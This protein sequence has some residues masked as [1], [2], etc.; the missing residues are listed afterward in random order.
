MSTWALAFDVV[1][2]VLLVATISYAAVLNRKLSALRSAKDEL[3]KLLGSFGEATARAD[4]GLEAIRQA[5]A[6]SGQALQSQVE[7]ARSLTAD[8]QFLV[9]RAGLAA[10]KTESAI[11]NDR[12]EAVGK[13]VST[14]ARK[15]AASGALAS[16]AGRET[17]RAAPKPVFKGTAAVRPRPRQA[18]PEPQVSDEQVALIKALDGV[19]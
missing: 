13:A 7:E 11:A 18:E 3:A 4:A 17:P 16:V 15:R 5:A 1:I 19:R 8:L 14:M 10:D 2:A 6:S 9:E 12:A